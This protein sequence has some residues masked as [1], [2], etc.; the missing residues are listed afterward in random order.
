MKVQKKMLYTTVLLRH[1]QINHVLINNYDTILKKVN[2][3]NESTFFL[4][5]SYMYKLHVQ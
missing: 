2:F 5:F 3:I 4:F 1:S